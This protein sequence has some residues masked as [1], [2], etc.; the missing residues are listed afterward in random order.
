[1]NYGKM[2]HSTF[3]KA[4]ILGAALI[5]A[6]SAFASSKASLNLSNPVTVN[7]TKL[8]AGEYKIQWEGSGPDV[9][10]SIM[11]GKTVVAKA[12]AHVVNLDAAAINSAAVVT[13]SNDGTATLTGVRFDGK[14]FALDLGESSDNMQAGSAK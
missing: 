3:S 8:K 9:E 6:S 10:V 12:P 2:K 5:L 14:K 13:T 11:Q 7:G 1:M 4:L